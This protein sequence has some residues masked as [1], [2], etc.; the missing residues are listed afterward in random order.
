MSF[1]EA[2]SRDSDVEKERP[3]T[4]GALSP[5]LNILQDMQNL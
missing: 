3:T 4:T 5:V 1:L 2:E